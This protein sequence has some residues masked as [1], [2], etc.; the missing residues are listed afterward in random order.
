[1]NEKSKKWLRFRLAT[2]LGFSLILMIALISRAYQL[3]IMSGQALKSIADRQHTKKLAL[4][5]ERGAII[6]R[7][8]QELAATIL[9]DSVYAD[10]S[11]IED[12]GKI[13]AKLSSALYVKKKEIINRLSRGRNFSWIARQISPDQAK[14]ISALNLK[15]IHLIKEPKRFYPH[16]EL[17]SH[18]IGFSGFDSN[19]LEGL[20]LEYDSFLKNVPDKALWKRDARGNRIYQKGQGRAIGDNGASNL[21]LTIDN[22]IQYIIEAQL[23]DA[24]KKTDAKGGTVIVMDPRT[25]G[26][27]AMANMPQFNP[28]AFSRYSQDT[29]RNRAVT[30]VFDPGSIFKPFLAAA[31]LEEG[32]AAETDIID[33]ENGSYKVKNVTIREAQLHKFKE[34]TLREVLKYS[35]NIGSTK[36]AER[37]GKEKYFDYIEKFGFGSKTGID[38]PGEVS[39]ILRNAD[40]WTEVDLATIA[41][42]QGVSVTAIQLI[43]AISAIANHG[44]MMKPHV[45]KG[46]IDNNREVV[47]EFK[48]QV[49]RR[50]VSPVTAD[51]IKSIMVEVVEDGTGKR[52]RMNDVT[53]AG[54]TGTSQ[55]FDFSEGK[56]S[57]EKIVASFVGFLPAENPR[58]AI[59]VM[60]DEPKTH[61]WGGEAAAPVFKSISEQMLRRFSR[62]IELREVVA[63]EGVDTVEIVR[64]A[65]HDGMMASTEMENDGSIVPNFTGMSVREVLNI[66][67][68]R[69]IDAE[70]S[71]TGWAVSQK[72]LPGFPRKEY[73]SVHVVFGKGF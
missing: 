53:V 25:G 7:N 48:P 47:R 49:V 60:L 44:V 39:G 11:G 70:I 24:V 41:F 9:V 4:Q 65:V 14:R 16:K 38:L 57:S 26:V 40:R 20:E 18:L 64:A 1:M 8:G 34:L 35:S 52:A 32:I 67:R 5:I 45:V 59:L 66:C 50:V 29:F 56:Y 27:L 63:S 15:G 36:I 72:P 6:D 12:P 3:Q 17:A 71:G 42:G 46:M 37:L 23:K 62:D 51:I 31:A 19:G 58:I 73:Q 22:K 13:S 69:G 43:A 54:K 33:C 30:D 2:I 28:N 55:K 68:E 61:K 21:L 10:P